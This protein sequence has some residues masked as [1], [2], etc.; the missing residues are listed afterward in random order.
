MHQIR[1]VLK[2]RSYIIKKYLA[3]STLT[4]YLFISLAYIFFLPKYT[5]ANQDAQNHTAVV[6]L[7]AF[8]ADILHRPTDSHSLFRKIFKS[9]TQKRRDPA[10]ILLLATVL[11]VCFIINCATSDLIKNAGHLQRFS[12]VSHQYYYLYFCSLRV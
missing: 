3:L 9:T 12:F 4:I 11:F 6:S 1:C 5:L 8:C 7:K 2:R 10:A